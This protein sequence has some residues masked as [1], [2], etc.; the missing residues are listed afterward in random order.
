VPYRWVEHTG[1]LELEL[2]AETEVGV[3]EEALAA[4]E[5][6]LSDDESAEPVQ[7]DVSLEAPDRPALLADWVAEL[8]FLAEIQGLVPQRAD[9]LELQ[10]KA[11]SARVL[12]HRGAPP[13]LVKGVTYHRLE[14]GRD[15]AGWLAR[16]VL[17]V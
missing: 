1:E 10:G 3:F 15:G 13:N 5:E 2:R 12:G 16:L 4:M 11:L 17:D 14:F 9:S 7:T 6:L 8:A